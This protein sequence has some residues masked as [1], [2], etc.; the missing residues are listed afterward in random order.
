MHNIQDVFFCYF[1]FWAQKAPT[2]SAFRLRFY[3]KIS[4]VGCKIFS[5]S[6]RNTCIKI[7]SSTMLETEGTDRRQRT[8]LYHQADSGQITLSLWYL[9]SLTFSFQWNCRQTETYGQGHPSDLASHH[10]WR[11]WKKKQL[12]RPKNHISIFFCLT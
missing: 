7:W 3:V 8:D 12:N 10:L 1:S 11:N 2:K 9:L 4:Q 6:V 5:F